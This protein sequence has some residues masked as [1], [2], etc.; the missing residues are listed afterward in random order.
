MQIDRKAADEK[1]A[2]GLSMYKGTAEV[3]PDEAKGL[4]LMY[5]AADECSPRAFCYFGDLAWHDKKYEDAFENYFLATGVNDKEGALLLARCYETGRGLIR[6]DKKR[7]DDLRRFVK[8]DEPCP[9]KWYGYWYPGL[10]EKRKA[11]RLKRKRPLPEPEND[12]PPA[13]QEL[14]ATLTSLFSGSESSRLRPALYKLYTLTSHTDKLFSAWP[15]TRQGLLACPD[16][17]DIWVVSAGGLGKAAQL[18]PVPEWLPFFEEFAAA[19]RQVRDIGLPF[20]IDAVEVRKIGPKDPRTALHGKHG[21][22]VKKGHQLDVGAVIAFYGGLVMQDE[23]AS[24]EFGAFIELNTSEYGWGFSAQFDNGKK[25]VIDASAV[26]DE[27]ESY[28]G[29]VTR[30]INDCRLQPSACV[31]GVATKDDLKRQNCDAVELVCHGV[32]FVAMKMSKKVTSEQEILIDYNVDYWHRAPQ[33]HAARSY[34]S[35]KRRKLLHL[36]DGQQPDL[37]QENKNERKG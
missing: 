25:Y 22:F 19:D 36:V 11:D 16:K 37:E 15:K 18:K 1:F 13:K 3:S 32:P 30:F 4:A 28:F 6:A 12:T 20:A 33:I 24:E 5:E 34:V 35:A 14:Q 17:Q 9:P 29:N 7:A 26:Q 31:N 8:L 10:F 21:L 2:L 23:M 27:K